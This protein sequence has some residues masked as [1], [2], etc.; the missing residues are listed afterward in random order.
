MSLETNRLLLR[1]WQRAD[2]APFAELN[3]DPNVRRFFPKVQTPEE[4]NAD[5]QIIHD[6]IARK[7]WG[8]WAVELKE[9]AEFIGF[10]GLFEPTAALPFSPCVEIAWRLRKEHWGSGYATEA[11]AKALSYAFE[12]LALDEVISMAVV[13]NA[14]SIAVMTRL[15][16]QDAKQ[17]FA[18]PDIPLEHELSEHVLYKITREQ[19][20]SQLSL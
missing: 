3:A 2:Y 8:L 4:S 14:P 6:F 7:G 12:T 19:W 17:N 13:S 16:L 1:Q 9:S 11:G 15:G 20:L 18:H 10:V 5:A